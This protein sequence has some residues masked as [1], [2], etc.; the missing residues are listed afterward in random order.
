MYIVTGAN[1]G[2]GKAITETLAKSGYRVIMACRNRQKAEQLRKQIV[3]LSGNSEIEI[4]ELNLASF[5]SVQ[6]FAVQQLRRGEKI[7]ALINNAGVMCREFGLTEDGMEQMLQVNY[8]SP[9]LLTHLLLPA[10]A[11]GGRIINTSSCTYRLGKADE[12]FFDVT[13]ENY[14]LFKIYGRSKLGV[15]MFT[16]ELARRLKDQKITVNAVDPGVVN[17]GMITMHRWF[18]PLTNLFFRPFI[19]SPQ[20]G[21]ATSLH[22]ALSEAGRSV[23]GGFWVNRHL[24]EMPPKARQREALEKLWEL[25]EGKLKKYL[26]T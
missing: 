16:A 5:A 21:A 17:T 9:W 2:L 24:R 10:L 15:L 25:T 26:K 18:D 22:L 6:R 20:K 11:G 23:S 1:G 3:S 13:A 7:E 19:K 4:G 8:A 12:H 14:G